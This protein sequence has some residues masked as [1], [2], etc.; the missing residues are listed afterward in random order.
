MKDSGGDG[1]SLADGN[2]NYYATEDTDH[3]YDRGR[4]EFQRT[5][6]R[7]GYDATI[8]STMSI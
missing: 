3:G 1:M 6:R 8:D 5:Y 7:H 4:T 2:P